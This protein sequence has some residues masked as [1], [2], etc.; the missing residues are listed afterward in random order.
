[1][2]LSRADGFSSC[3][4]TLVAPDAVLLDFLA[5]RE[6]SDAVLLLFLRFAPPLNSRID[7]M[8]VPAVFWMPKGMVLMFAEDTPQV[9]AI[10]MDAKHRLWNLK[11]LM[12][13]RIKDEKGT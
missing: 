2:V 1:M 5:L 12:V 9:D 7:W 4:P 8:L 10:N 6:D 3:F 11:G 13:K